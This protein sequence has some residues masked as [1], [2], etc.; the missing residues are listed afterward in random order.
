[1]NHVIFSLE[2]GDFQ[3]MVGS[4]IKMTDDLSKEV[5]KEK[6]KVKIMPKF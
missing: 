6:L 5:E 4:F 3:N 1:M 2:I